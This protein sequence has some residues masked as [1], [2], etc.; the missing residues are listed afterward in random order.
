L[1]PES[2]FKGDKEKDR[3]REGGREEK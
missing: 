2:S 3:E 1:L